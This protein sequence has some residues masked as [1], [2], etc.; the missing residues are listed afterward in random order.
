LAGFT[1][2][3]AIEDCLPQEGDLAR[4][5]AIRFGFDDGESLRCAL[6]V[7]YALAQSDAGDREAELGERASDIS[8]R[9]SSDRHVGRL[10]ARAFRRGAVDVVPSQR[11]QPRGSEAVAVSNRDGRGVPMPGAVL[12]SGLD[13]PLVNPHAAC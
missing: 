10:E 3:K 12:L 4:G 8:P 5:F 11:H 9:A 1:G 7:D 6:G 13:E 2:L